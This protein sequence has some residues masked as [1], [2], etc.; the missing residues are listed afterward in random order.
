MGYGDD[1]LI[2]V[3]WYDLP[4]HES[5]L[6]APYSLQ[7]A[8]GDGILDECEFDSDGDGLFD[9][10]D[11]CPFDPDNDIDGDGVCGDVDNC[12]DVPNPDQADSDGDGIGDACEAAPEPQPQP[13]PEY[14][15]EMLRLALSF[16]CGTP[17]CGL[18]GI[19]GLPLTLAGWAALKVQWRRKRRHG[20]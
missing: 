11:P 15:R 12:P 20:R 13:E 3:Y 2:E 9:F 6:Y 7:D 1:E 14:D 10:Q 5:W 17:I 18:F 4:E 19:A 8:D 16:L